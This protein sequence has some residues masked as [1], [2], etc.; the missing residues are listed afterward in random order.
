[1][2]DN[3]N[4]NTLNFD[5]F[6]LPHCVYWSINQRNDPDTFADWS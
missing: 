2:D 1:V 5:I 4:K 3:E 6:A